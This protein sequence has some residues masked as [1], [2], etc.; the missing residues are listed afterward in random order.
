MGN[1]ELRYTSESFTFFMEG[2]DDAVEAL[3]Q[4]RLRVAE[5]HVTEAIAATESM[6]KEVINL[7]KIV[8]GY[9]S[10][11]SPREVIEKE[12]AL[13]RD[14]IKKFDVMIESWKDKLISTEK[15][16]KEKEEGLEAKIGENQ[17]ISKENEELRTRIA[18]Q[19][20]NVRD[21]ERMKKELQAV[22]RDVVETEIGRNILEEKS[23]ELDADIN[24]KMR[25]LES[26]VEQANY[27]IKK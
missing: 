19:V 22:E 20:M 27:T 11:P 5:E 25:E 23:W 1:E 3:D 18:S 10:G 15:L 8:E 14:D 2:D 17:R 7:E 21:A 13:L 26:L 12:R 16:L 24:R 6:E 4:E 9:R